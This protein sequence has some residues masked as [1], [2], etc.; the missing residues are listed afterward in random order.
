MKNRDAV[1]TLSK[2][3]SAISEASSMSISSY[4]ETEARAITFQTTLG[5]VTV[6]KDGKVIIDTAEKVATFEKAI[7]R[8]QEVAMVSG[9]AGEPCYAC[10]GTGRM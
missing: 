4:S 2:A 3:V 6:T 5:E 1:A 9:S 7:K 10:N 8:L